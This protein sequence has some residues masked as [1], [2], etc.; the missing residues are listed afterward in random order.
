MICSMCRASREG[1]SS[2]SAATSSWRRSSNRALEMTEPAARAAPAAD[3]HRPRPGHGPRRP[4]S[5]RPG[6][7]QS[8]HERRQVQRGRRP[9]PHPHGAR[10]C[11]WRRSASPTTVSA[12][13]PRCMG[14]VFDAFVQQPSDAGAFAR[15][16][17]D[18]GCRS[19]RVSSRPT[20]TR[21]P[22]TARARARAARSSSSC[23]AIDGP[24]SAARRRRARTTDCTRSPGPG[25]SSSSMTT[26]MRPSRCK[27]A[28]EALGQVVAVAHDGPSALREAATVRA[29]DRPARH[30]AARHG[31]LRARRRVARG[32]RPSPGRDHGL[33]PAARPPALAR[34]G[35]R[36]APGEAGRPRAARRPCC[37][38]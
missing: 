2:S 24:R 38:G 15:A 8:D 7:G 4:R 36:G 29:G 25:G 32:P 12:S 6:G 9:D 11:G 20:G 18:S 16:G 5:A 3:H 21:C 34:R 37:N 13:R 26:V 19:S 35:F 27:R 1:W 10:R 23:P 30:R 28:L 33:R 22:R 17:S 31:W 14:K